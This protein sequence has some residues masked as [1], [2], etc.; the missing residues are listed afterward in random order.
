MKKELDEKLDEMIIGTI[1][2]AGLLF[3]AGCV[4][5]AKLFKVR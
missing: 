1:I 4:A 5:C 3:L 2:A